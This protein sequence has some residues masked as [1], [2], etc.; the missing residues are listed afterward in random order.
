M[1]NRYTT[2]CKTPTPTSVPFKPPLS[3][4]FYNSLRFP[5]PA[6]SAI[7]PAKASRKPQTARTTRGLIEYVPV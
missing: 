3:N 2:V 5:P 1:N 4:P 7:I 6:T